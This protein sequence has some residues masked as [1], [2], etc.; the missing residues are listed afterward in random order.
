[1]ASQTVTHPAIEVVSGAS[2]ALVGLGALSFALI[3]LALPI[4]IL[5]VVATIPLLLPVVALALL[6]FVVAAPVL[7]VRRLIA[8]R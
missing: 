3:P 1:M 8:R 2:V 7:L 4:L 5:T 6:G